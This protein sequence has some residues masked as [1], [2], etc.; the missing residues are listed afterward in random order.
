LK[1]FGPWVKKTGTLMW[2]AFHYEYWDSNVNTLIGIMPTA[3]Y[4]IL[5]V[6]IK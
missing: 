6:T 1:G 2:A 4:L 3:L 5:L